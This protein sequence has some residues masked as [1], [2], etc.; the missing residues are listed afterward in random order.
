[1]GA[2]LFNFIGFS[3]R[4]RREVDAAALARDFPAD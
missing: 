2:V 1:M 3:D 4:L